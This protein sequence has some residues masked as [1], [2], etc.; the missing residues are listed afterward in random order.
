M[1]RK[2]GLLS[3][4]FAAVVIWLGIA[5]VVSANVDW[6]LGKEINLNVRPL[7]IAVSADGKF[8]FI[9][10]PGEILVYSHDE[11]KVTDRLKID[12]KFNKIAYTEKNNTV[13]LADTSANTIKM[14]RFDIVHDIEISQLPFKGPA[15]APVT[16][17]VFDDYQ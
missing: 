13:V 4:F 14:Y 11:E 12:K 6:Q 10:T 9:L 2:S 8:I 5:G 17:T 16:I 1:K 15:A 3:L 7:D